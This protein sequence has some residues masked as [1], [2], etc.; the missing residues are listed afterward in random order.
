M[1]GATMC[2]FYIGDCCVEGR[3]SGAVLS[4]TTVSI[5]EVRNVMDGIVRWIKRIRLRTID[6]AVGLDILGLC[7]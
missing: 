5:V 7:D 6:V 1:L 2:G 4:K 3:V